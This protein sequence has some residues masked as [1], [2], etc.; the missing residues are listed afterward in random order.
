MNSKR[1][2][3]SRSRSFEESPFVPRLEP[4]DLPHHIVVRSHGLMDRFSS[5]DC[6]GNLFS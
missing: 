1:D 2:L 5:F 4:F 6:N 3:P